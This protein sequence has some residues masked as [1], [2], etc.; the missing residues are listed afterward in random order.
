MYR[1][2]YFFRFLVLSYELIFEFNSASTKQSLLDSLP[3][4]LKTSL[5]VLDTDLSQFS[6]LLKVDCESEMIPNPHHSLFRVYKNQKIQQKSLRFLS[7]VNG[8]KSTE[9]VEAELFWKEK[10]T[11]QN[12]KIA[13]LDSGFSSMD[14]KY[15]NVVECINFTNEPQCEDTTGHGTTVASIIASTHPDCPG[16]AP[17][18]LLYPLKVF[19]SN[20]ESQTSWFLEAF[21]YV[22]RNKIKILN[23]S[24]GGINFM[25]EPFVS[26]ISELVN[27]GVIIVS[28]AGNDGPGFGTLSNPGDQGEVIGVG[29]LDET[30]IRVSD[31][32][33]RGPTLW[34]ISGGMGRF[35]P[36]IVT[37]STNIKALFRGECISKTGTSIATPLVTGAIALLYPNSRSPG[38][39]KM[40][41][42]KTADLLEQNSI[43]E[44][45]AGKMNL[46]NADVYLNHGANDELLVFPPYFNNTQTYFYPYNLQ[47]LYPESP[48]LVINFTVTHPT[49]NKGELTVK[50]IKGAKSLSYFTELTGF[51]AFTATFAVFL[52]AR[53][54]FDKESLRIRLEG[55]KM[56][57]EVRVEVKGGGVVKKDKRILWDLTHNAKF[58]EAGT[59]IRDELDGSYLLDWRGDHP[60]T[61]HL[62]LY[63]YLVKQNYVIDF[64][65][66]DFSCI[67]GEL[68]STY[69]LIDP[70][71]KFTDYD[72]KK[73]Q[74]DL[75][76]H[77][78]ALIIFADWSDSKTLNEQ[79]SISK[80]EK[81]IPGCNVNTLNTLLT[82]YFV[83]LSTSKSFSDTG[84][85][86]SNKISVKYI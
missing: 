48:P 23:L 67:K 51:N 21:S 20:Q 11:G 43:F 37:Y 80:L 63:E 16:L 54:G 75:E 59:V 18:S 4:N 31:F 14:K 56:K 69:L 1:Y 26:K 32:S 12:V 7:E 73:I 38:L 10:S 6:T 77:D 68:Y 66:S 39:I 13:I 50:D 84:R 40:S 22:L 71:Q 62:G 81:G 58:P 35:K 2:L 15:I 30:G 29:G 82:P 60:F 27:N 55:G 64:L 24:N 36:D 8:V 65:L 61:N 52:Y 53:E 70:E 83:E 46:T 9:V 76:K 79:L 45:G 42:L 34:E 74:F 41:L 47:P 57:A 28:A 86:G 33:S 78:L 25:D 44:Q 17:S 5:T 85:I 19:D 3:L 49:M 72:I